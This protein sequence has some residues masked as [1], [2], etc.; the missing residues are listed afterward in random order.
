MNGRTQGENT[1]LVFFQI[2]LYSGGLSSLSV[3]YIIIGSENGAK[4]LNIASYKEASK[5]YFRCAFY[6]SMAVLSGSLGF[7]Y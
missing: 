2:D 4:V 6:S 1:L 7:Y 5:I 3:M